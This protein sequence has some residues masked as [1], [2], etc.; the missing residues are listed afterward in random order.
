MEVKNSSSAMAAP[1]PD[2]RGPASQSLVAPLRVG[3][4]AMLKT[5]NVVP[6]PGKWACS[7]AGDP[8]RR[9]G[10]TGRHVLGF[11]ERQ[12]IRVDLVLMRSAHAVRRAFIDFQLSSLDDFG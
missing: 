8:A 3:V 9:A 6:F 10:N 1:R 11:D 2:R 7:P 5:T 4:E 12:Q